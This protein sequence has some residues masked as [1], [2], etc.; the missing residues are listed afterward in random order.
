MLE[1]AKVKYEFLKAIAEVG[2]DSNNFET[3]TI[4]GNLGYK[5]LYTSE[6]EKKFSQFGSIQYEPG[7]YISLANTTEEEAFGY[8]CVGFVKAVSNLKHTLT[9]EWIRDLDITPFTMPDKGHV[10]ATFGSDDKYN[11]GHVAI[12]ISVH[13]DGVYV[14]YQN[15]DGTGANPVGKVYI[16]KI[17]FD[18]P[19]YWTNDLNRYSTVKI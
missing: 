15:T 1:Q 8:Q 2:R 4:N 14:I 12:V 7:G 13:S 18:G 19:G 11:H 3:T 10:I 9:K 16:R 17:I 6:T 5:F